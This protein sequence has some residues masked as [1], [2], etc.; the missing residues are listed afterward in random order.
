MQP[1]GQTKTQGASL[2]PDSTFTVSQSE[3][4]VAVS[5]A[6]E[7]QLEQHSKVPRK[8]SY[9][10][11]DNLIISGQA[12]RPSKRSFDAASL[13][14]SSNTMSSFMMGSSGPLESIVELDED[15]DMDS[16]LN[17]PD[18]SI[19]NTFVDDDCNG[20]DDNKS[21]NSDSLQT[22][23]KR[24]SQRTRGRPWWSISEQPESKDP[25]EKYDPKTCIFE[26]PSTAMKPSSKI[27]F[28]I[29]SDIR[30]ADLLYMVAEKLKQFPGSV[31]LCYKLESNKVKDGATMIASEDELQIFKN[32]MCQLIIPQCLASSKIS[33][34]TLKPVTVVFEDA[35]ND[36][37]ENDVTS[38]KGKKKAS[39]AGATTNPAP[40]N[41]ILCCLQEVTAELQQ[42][43]HCAFH[44]KEDNNVYCYTITSEGQS[45][46]EVCYALSNSHIGFWALEIAVNQTSMEDK[47]VR[48]LLKATR[49][50]SHTAQQLGMVSELNP[51]ETRGHTAYEAS[52]RPP[53]PGAS[54]LHIS[55]VLPQ[56]WGYQP[57][58]AT[59]LHSEAHPAGGLFIPGPNPYV[60]L[61]SQ[62]GL[63][64]QGLMNS[65][66]QQAG[67]KMPDI[68]EWFKSLD[69]NEDCQVDSIEY[70]K[71]SPMLW[72]QGFRRIIQI[73]PSYITLEHLQQWLGVNPGTATFIFHYAKEDVATFRAWGLQE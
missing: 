37:S 38:G 28:M 47:P 36:D 8:R 24:P 32:R 21:H 73:S 51:S 60:N 20:T 69:N 50:C 31:K 25:S 65:S 35:A 34:H 15:E 56:P 11:C 48:L 22:N 70:A 55:F 3:S 59:G 71:F 17:D 43:W 6:N 66:Q 49:P 63:P 16:E 12:L 23:V 14:S 72:E 54:Y 57:Q 68:L 41:D 30:L 2:P 5:A 9:M 27:P 10:E 4:P 44:S 40:S 61:P 52:N 53:P 67:G 42:R 29:K 7:P 13:Q 33:G 1:R 64:S 18:E 46:G 45:K 39:S 62:P 26:I 19:L 58:P